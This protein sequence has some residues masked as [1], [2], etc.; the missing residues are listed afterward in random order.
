M[1]L[2]FRSKG[3]KAVVSAVLALV[4]VIIAFG[5]MTDWTYPVSSYISVITKP[6]QT[7]FYD[8]GE[9]I[10]GFFENISE[11]ER[12]KKENKELKEKI[13]EMTAEMVD[14]EK[15]KKEYESIK[16]FMGIK[17]EHP[18]YEM[19][20]AMIIA[21]DT[22][23][24]YGTFTINKGT[25]NGVS[26]RAPVITSAGLVGYISSAGASQS[27]V[28]SVLNPS[29][30]ITAF[31]NRTDDAGLVCGANDYARDG[32][33]IIKNLKRNNMASAGDS[34]ISSGAGGV[35]PKG[36][37]IGVIS[38]IKQ[39]NNETDIYAVIEPSADIY[40]AKNVMVITKY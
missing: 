7:F 25:L 13:D 27:T 17:T 10:N 39:S 37:I 9:S 20:P 40:N 4:M 18:E 23:D 21:R 26:E 14:F 35:F 19:E 30:N 32:L 16:N 11:T 22:T 1:R 38:E 8:T 12:I 28:I 6:V 33:C 5:A 31:V 36:L 24:S 2:F 34:I 15:T 3:F 29:L